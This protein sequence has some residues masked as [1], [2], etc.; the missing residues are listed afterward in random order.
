MYK[1]G[2]GEQELGEANE[3][4]VEF[5]KQLEA[6]P[7]I[8]TQ[9]VAK[10][11]VLIRRSNRS[12]RSS[13]GCEAILQ[14]NCIAGYLRYRFLVRLGGA[15]NAAIDLTG[16][17]QYNPSDYEHGQERRMRTRLPIQH[18]RY[19][20]VRSHWRASRQWARVDWRSSA[21]YC[22]RRRCIAVSC[23]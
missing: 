22:G 5:Q 11:G 18:R 14:A 8:A 4:D 6:R 9:D 17:R 21:G 19:Q 3:E 13:V 7:E 16:G 15:Q 20:S 12:Q 23:G 2:R 1:L 10:I